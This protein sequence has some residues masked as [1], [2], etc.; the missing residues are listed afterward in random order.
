MSSNE[1]IDEIMEE[2]NDIRPCI[3][4]IDEAD[5]VFGHRTGGF[6]NSVTNKLLSVMDGANGKNPDVVFVAAT[7][8]PDNF[9]AAALRGGRF[10]EKVEFELPDAKAIESFVKDW[11]A[12]KPKLTVDFDLTRASVTMQGLSI[13][14]ITATLQQAVND[15]ITSGETCIKQ[16]NLEAALLKLKL[17]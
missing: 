9:D 12:H 15:T 3:V 13:A 16:N 2:A 10:T 8:H 11:F 5:D 14:N 1:R 17:N 7:N 6:G 4:F